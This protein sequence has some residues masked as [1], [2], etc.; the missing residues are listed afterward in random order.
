ML[1]ARD[2]KGIINISA[3]TLRNETFYISQVIFHDN[4]LFSG[5]QA[6]L[7]SKEKRLGKKG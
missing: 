5:H 4:R 2:N 1:F 3:N 7:L 6:E